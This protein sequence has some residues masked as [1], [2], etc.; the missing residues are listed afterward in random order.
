MRLENN[1]NFNSLFDVFV[2]TNGRESFDYVIQSLKNQIGVTSN[3]IEVRDKTWLDACNYCLAY[4]DKPYYFRIDDDMIL[5]PMTFLFYFEAVKNNKEENVV[6]FNYKLWEPWNK[7]LAGNLKV[8]NRKLTKVLGFEVDKNGRVDKIFKQK[9]EQNN[10]KYASDKYSCVGIH[11]AC[12]YKDNMFYS[13]LR[14]EKGTERYKGRLKEIKFLDEVYKKF[15]LSKQLEMSNED[16]Y[17]YN[18]NNNTKFF[19][20]IEKTVL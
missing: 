20:F 1:M 16:V 4:S 2:I 7:R 14:K 12:S 19:K 15:P 9:S 17:L 13:E 3:I 8:Y 5:H 11:A 18:K 6:L 10:F